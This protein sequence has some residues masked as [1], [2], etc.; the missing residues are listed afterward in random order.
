M[1]QAFTIARRPRTTRYDLGASSRICALRHAQFRSTPDVLRDL[2]DGV[3]RVS[4]IARFGRARLT[5]AATV[6]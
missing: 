1:Q 5:R 2:A 4:R 6:T 3:T